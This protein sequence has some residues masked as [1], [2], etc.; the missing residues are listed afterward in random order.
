MISG[1]A[2]IPFLRSD[3]VASNTARACISLISG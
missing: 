2:S 1:I 3:A